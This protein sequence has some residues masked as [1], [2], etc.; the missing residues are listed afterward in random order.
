LLGLAVWTAG[1]TGRDATS[2][3]FWR[4][5]G[6]AGLAFA[7]AMLLGVGLA[8]VTTSLRLRAGGLLVGLCVAALVVPRYL[9]AVAWVDMLGPAGRIT[10]LWRAAPNEPS[11]LVDHWIYT[12]GSCGLLLGCCLFP[13][14]YLAARAA[15]LRADPGALEAARLARGAGGELRVAWATAWPQA[16]AGGLLAAALAGLEFAVPQ[17]LRIRV[18]A[19]EVYFHMS[20]RAPAAAFQAAVPLSALALAFALAALLLWVRRPLPA[21]RGVRPRRP[22][23]AGAVAAWGLGLLVLVPGLWLPLGSLA[24]RLFD[25]A[26]TASP[27]ESA[28][29]LR[30]MREAWAVG[31]GDAWRSLQVGLGTA[32]LGLA[33]AVALGWPLRRQGGWVLAVGACVLTALLTV[34]APLV[35]T[36]LLVAFNRPGLAWFLDHLGVVGVA[37]LIRFLPVAALIAW[38]SLARSPREPEE[39]A[40][41]AGRGGWAR[42]VGV[43]LPAA[44]PALLAAWSIL[45]VLTVTEYGAGVLVVPPGASILSVFVVNEAHYGQGDYLAGLFVLLLA[46]VLA[47]LA[48]A[49]VW[50]GGRRLVGRLA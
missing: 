8:L 10:T 4:S 21:S 5:A 32:T 42:L 28:P 50:R 43:G 16:L 27:G 17:L 35:G 48:L 29:A 45:Y 44:W 18:Q 20:D 9:A 46:V 6:I 39:A 1:G 19:E 2:A 23:T 13:L 12:W 26:G 33:L 49:G 36:G 41:L 22:T 37:C 15:L 38:A 30:V 34:P 14:P 11:L 25:A 31:S 24:L 3:P 7:V 47:P 40:L